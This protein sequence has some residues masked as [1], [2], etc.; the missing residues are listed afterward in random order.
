MLTATLLTESPELPAAEL[1][2]AKRNGEHGSTVAPVRK[3]ELQ[4]SYTV[5]V[6]EVPLMD[7]WEGKAHLP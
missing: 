3:A 7:C 4:R 2:D 6:E 1:G 5:K